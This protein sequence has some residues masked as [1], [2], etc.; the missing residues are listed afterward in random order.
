VSNF[1]LDTVAAVR[2]TKSFGLGLDS[3]IQQ[4]KARR[5]MFLPIAADIDR[6]DNLSICRLTRAFRAGTEGTGCFVQCSQGCTTKPSRHHLDW[7]Q[8]FPKDTR[9]G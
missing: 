5:M 7:W 6:L 9:I 2:C 4:G 8:M 1:L 3:K